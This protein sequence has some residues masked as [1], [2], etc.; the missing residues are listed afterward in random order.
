MIQAR[1]SA[2]AGEDVRHIAP[3]RRYL[4]GLALAMLAAPQLT[5]AQTTGNQADKNAKVAWTIAPTT[6]PESA[7]RAVIT[8]RGSVRDNWH[9]YAFKQRATGPLPLVVAVGSNDAAIAGGVVAG[10]APTVAFD[11]AFGFVTPYYERSFSL[12]VPVR[13]RAGL[14]PGRRTVPIS[15]RYQSCDGRV[16]EPPKTVQLLAPIE[17]GAGA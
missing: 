4:C 10:S 14:A 16:C 11:P 15:V 7:R 9:I 13:L 6:V 17:I 12:T 1:R 2:R 8:L 3:S 5:S